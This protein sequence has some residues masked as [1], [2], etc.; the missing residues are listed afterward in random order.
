[1]QVKKKV[2]RDLQPPALGTGM[3]FCPSTLLRTSGDLRF[4]GGSGNGGREFRV[5]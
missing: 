4:S 5:W 3:D 1:M 2:M